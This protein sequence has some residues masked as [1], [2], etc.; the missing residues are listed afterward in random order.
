MKIRIQHLFAVL[1]TLL[2]TC[3][4][5]Q[6]STAFAQ[7]TAFTY[8]GRLNDTGALA[9]G[10]Y[11]FRFRIASDPLANNYV[12]SPFLTNGVAVSNGL[13]IAI[14]D[15]GSGIFT[16]S[17]YWLE[18]DVR[19][20]GGSSYTGLN[21]LQQLTPAPYAIFAAGA[22]NLNGTISASQ[23]TGSVLNSQLAHNSITVN[24]GTALSGGGTAALG[25]SVTLNNAGVTALT[26]GGGVTVSASS[27]SVTLGS[28]ATSAN[29]ANAIVSR[30]ASGN[31]SAGSLTLAGNLTLPAA[32]GIDNIFAGTVQLMNADSNQNFFVGLGSGPNSSGSFADTGV[33]YNALNQS[34]G[35]QNTAIGAYALFSNN[36]CS[37]NTAVGYRALYADNIG[38]NYNTATGWEALAANQ[39]GVFNVADGEEA[40]LANTGGSY[41]VAVG[42]EALFASTGG[43]NTAV[44]DQ[45]LFGVATGTGNTAV[46]AGAGQSI[47]AGVNNIDV[48]EFADGGADESNTIRIGGEGTQDRTFI[49]GI[50]NS[51]SSG[52]V[53]VYINSNG[54]LGT[55]TS[56]ARFKRDIHGMKDAS[57]VLY[58]LEPV[59]FKYK[60]DIDPQ[61]IPQFGLIAEQVDRVDP[62]LVAR[63]DHGRAYSV[64]YEAVNAMLLNEFLK[65]HKRVEEQNAE[66]D[67]LKAKAAKVDL[68]EKRLDSLED[69]INSRTEP[70]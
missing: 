13:F 14:I 27:G 33:G 47:V 8:Q 3:V 18:V 19:T 12:G 21:P 55:T 54:R 30:N 63:D 34:I 9:N 70:K 44:G 22:S 5:S 35:T 4:N 58:S 53:P 26:G 10:T 23:L 11:D 65:E 50:W 67:A 62:D 52:G 31:F 66:I 41:N 25:G 42:G 64:R 69:K 57:E 24:A 15:F 61:G 68:L 29:T 37:N 28:T 49:A 48:G 17:N 2:L 45:A 40:L 43:Y 56:S 16:G 36:N 46:G 39:T 60:T 38:A 59:A 7:G 6:L 1:V 32:P 20:N 51:T